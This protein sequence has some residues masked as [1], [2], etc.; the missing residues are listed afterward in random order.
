MLRVF[1]APSRAVASA[2]QFPRFEFNTKRAAMRPQSP[3]Y[4]LSRLCRLLAALS[5]LS[6]APTQ[7]LR[8]AAL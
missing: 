6:L 7:A 1:C 3:S 4:R 8:A 2:R 5:L